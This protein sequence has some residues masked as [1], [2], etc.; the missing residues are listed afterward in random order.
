MGNL[1]PGETYIYERADGVI[2]AREFGAKPE[3]RKAIGWDWDPIT[4]HA[5]N[6]S[7]KEEEDLWRDIRKT[8][9]ENPS[10]QEA[11]DRVKVQYYLSK[12]NGNSKT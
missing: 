6:R 8:A 3:T 4:G 2:Y 7:Q 5:I 11:L 9:L 1:K 12:D 10:L